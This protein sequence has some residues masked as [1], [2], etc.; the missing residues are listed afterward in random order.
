MA[1]DEDERAYYKLRLSGLLAA[2]ATSMS[3]RDHHRAPHQWRGLN[4]TFGEP[5]NS[6]TSMFNISLYQTR[7]WKLAFVVQNSIYLSIAISRDRGGAGCG[8]DTKKLSGSDSIASIRPA[9]VD[10]PG[11]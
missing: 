7:I 4:R 8:P 6:N 10:F 1:A 11:P 9:R 3:K 2:F 5:R